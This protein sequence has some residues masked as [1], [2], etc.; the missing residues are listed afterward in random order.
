MTTNQKSTGGYTLLELLVTLSIGGILSVLAVPSFHTLL[1][2]HR[3]E[4]AAQ[5]LASDLR[6]ARQMAITEGTPTTVQ[7][8]PAIG[9]SWKKG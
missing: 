1:A 9:M 5:R 3:L 4:G 2:N 6:Y 7:L 8:N